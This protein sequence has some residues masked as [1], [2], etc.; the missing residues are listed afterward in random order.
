MHAITQSNLS[1]AWIEALEYLLA[2]P[3]GKAV[4]LA[5]AISQPEADEDATVRGA[6]D[7]FI[8]ARR[9]AGEP[10][11]PIGT[12]ANTI[13]PAAFYRPDRPEARERLYELHGRTQSLHRRMRA[14]ETYFNRL[15]AYPGPGGAPFNQLEYIVDR[16]IKQRTPRRDGHVVALSSAYEVGLSVPGDDLRVQAPGQD[17]NT[18]S[19]PCLSHISFTL[20]GDVLNLAALYRNQHFVARAYG[21]YIGLARIA[22]F[23]AREV[24]VQVGEILCLAT[25]AD[26]QISD[27]GKAGVEALVADARQPSIPALSA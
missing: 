6:L 18:R 3:H 11:W 21:N 27:F 23:I 24:D 9:D 19:F 4:H 2:A 17:R 7:R 13:F 12:V 20:E 14:P 26:A 1:L 8:G 25:H 22:A 15:V 10:L 5:V 16:L